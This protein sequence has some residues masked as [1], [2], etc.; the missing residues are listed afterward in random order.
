[1]YLIRTLENR[2]NI[3]F[4]VL[5]SSTLNLFGGTLEDLSSNVMFSGYYSVTI[6]ELILHFSS[7]VPFFPIDFD[8]SSKANL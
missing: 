4:I 5:L 6:Y 3:I 2:I 7:E 8:I 1:M